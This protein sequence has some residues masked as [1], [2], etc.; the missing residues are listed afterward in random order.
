MAATDYLLK[1]DG[2]DGESKDSKHPNSI[3]LAAFSWGESNSASF[4]QTGGGG[5]GKVAFQDLHCTAVTNKAS[6]NLMQDCASGKHR[7]KAEL[8][9]RKQGEKQ[10]DFYVVTLEDVLVSSFQTGGGGDQPTD[11]FSLAYA[12]IKFEYKPQKPDG[13]LDS[14]ITGEWNIPK[15]AKT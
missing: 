6:A 15:N 9:V 11:N 5:A 13:S 4:A 3:E 7:K 1:I 12:K 8:F 14:G 10:Q 2:I